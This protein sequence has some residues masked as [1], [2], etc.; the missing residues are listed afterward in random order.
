MGLGLGLGLNK[1]KGLIYFQNQ[2]S[3]YF[4]GSDDRVFT[5]ADAVAQPTSYSFWAKSSETGKNKGVFGHGAVNRGA[6]HFSWSSGM[7]LLYLSDTYYLYWGANAAQGDGKWHHWVVYSDTKNITNSKLYCD[8]VLQTIDIASSNTSGTANPYTEPLTIGAESSSQTANCFL[9]SMDEFAVFDRELTQAEITRMYNTYYTNN[10]VENGNFE[11][12]GGDIVQNGDFSEIGN[13]EVTNGTF[14]L[15][16]DVVENGDFSEIGNEE[17]TNGSFSEIGNEKITNGDFATDSDWTNEISGWTISNGKANY[18]GVNT[19]ASFQQNISLSVGK[20]YKVTYKISD[21]QQGDFRI[22]LGNTAGTINNSDGTYTEYITYSSGSIF[23]LQARSSFIGSID[24]VSVKEVGQDWGFGAG[25]GMG[26]G[27]AECDGTQTSGTQLTQTGLTLTN[28][29]IYK[30]TYK[31]TVSAGNIDARLQG[32]GATVTGPS[33]TSSD[34]YTDYLVS[35]G[36]TSF[37]MRG[38]DAFVGTVENISIKE[39]GQDWTLQNSS[40]INTDLATVVA[41]GAIS[42]TGNN[43]SLFQPNVFSP[44]KSYRIKFR[45]RQTN[46]SGNFNV[47]YGYG[48]I[49]DEVITSSFVDYCI[50]FTTTSSSWVNELTFGGYTTGDTFEVDD[51]VVQE[52]NWE[53]TQSTISGGEATITSTDGSY[54]GI[55]QTGV[56][57]VGKA[58]F[59]SFNVKSI[60]GTGQFRA[61]ANA[62]D[63]TTNGLITGYIIAT[64]SQTLEIKRIGGAFSAIIDNVIVKEVGQHWTLQNGWNMGDGVAIFSGSV[65]AY[66]KLFQDNFLN[67]G[68]QYK[69]TFEIKSISLGSIANIEP[70]SPSFNSTGVKTQYFTATFDDLYLEPTSD[71]VLTIDN[72]TVQ[73]V[74][75]NWTLNNGWSVDDTK[76][77]N[78]GSGGQIYPTS[79][80]WKSG[81]TTKFQITVSGRT[82]GHIRI[83]NPASSIYYVNNINTNDTFE[84]SFNTIDASGWRI[85]AVSGFDGSIDNIVVQQQKH[86]ATNLLVNSGDYQ[87]ANPLLTSTKSMYFDGIDSYIEVQDDSSLQLEASPSTWT[88]WARLDGLSD[89]D[90]KFIAKAVSTGSDLSG[91]QIRTNNADL[92]F[93]SYDGGW[94]GVTASSFFTDLNWVN[95]T[96]TLDSSNLASF[97]KN[98]VLFSSG[99]LGADIPANTGEMLF[100]ARTPAVPVNFLEGQMTEVGI[101]DRALTSLEVASLYN[102]G[103]PTDLLVNRNNYQSGNPTVFNTKQVDF[104]GI[105]DYMDLGSK[106]AT[107]SLTYSAWVKLTDNS[108][109]SVLQIG[110]TLLRLGNAGVIQWWSDIS[111]TELATSISSVEDEWSHIVVTQTGQNAFVYLNGVQENST[112]SQAVVSTSSNDSAIGKYVNANT[113]H[114]TGEISQVGVW[115]EALTADEVSSLYNHGLPIDLMTDQAAYESSSNLV[116]YWRMGSGTNDGFP[117]ISDQLSPSLDHISTTNLLTYS[118][119]F[120]QWTDYGASGV[121]SEETIFGKNAYKI[122]EDNT[123]N[124]HGVYL[125]NLF[126]ANGSSHS[127]SVYVKG[128]ERRYVVLTARAGIS[129]NASAIIFDTQEGEWVLD[130]SNQTQASSAESVGNG[131]WRIAITGDPTSAAYDSFT[132]A[133]SLGGTSYTDANYQ[134]DGTSGVY[135]YGAQLEQHPIATPYVKSN[136]IPGQRKSSTTNTLLYSEDFSKYSTGG[137][138]PTLTT[139]QLA[140]D[141]TFTATKVSGVSQ[142]TSLYRGSESST[143]ATRS[144]YARTV[145]GTGTANLMSYGSNTN[146]NFTITEE[147][148]RFELTGSNSTGGNNFYAVDFRFPGANPLTELIIWGGQSEEQTQATPYIKTVGSPVTVE[149]YKENNYAEM[150]NLGGGANFSRGIEN[151]SPYANI[152]RDSDFT[153]TGTQAQNIAGGYWTTGAGWTIANGVASCNNTISAHLSQN[154]LTLGVTYRV[155]YQIK[156]YT[157]GSVRVNAGWGGYGT[158]RSDEGTYTE[159]LVCTGNTFIE[160]TSIGGGFVGSIDNVTVTEVNTG[161]QG[162][163]KMGDGINDEYPVIYDQ[164]NPTLGSELLSQPVNL[165]AD[166]SATSGG[167]IVDADTFTTGGGSTDGIIK[168]VTT[169][170]KTYKLTIDGNTTSSGFTIGSGGSSGNEYGSGF[171]TFYFTALHATLWIRQ[172]T[173]GTTNITSFTLKQVGGNPATMTSMPEGNI[174]NQFP[175]TK[176]RNYYRMGDGILDSKFLSYP[177]LQSQAPYI[178]QDQTSPNLAHIPTTNLVTYS[179]DLSVLQKVSVGTASAPVTTSNYAAA[180]DG[181]QTATR[182]VFNLNGGTTNQD[183]SILR[184]AVPQG[185]NYYFSIY[186]KSTDGTEQKILWHDGGEYNLTTVTN[187]WVRITYDGR[188]NLVYS[189]I[190]LRGGDGVDSSDILAWGFQVEEQAQATAYLKSDGIAAVRKSSTTN[191]FLYSEDFENP[192]FVWLKAGTV[193][194]T[195]N[196]GVSPIGTQNSTR[197]VFGSSNNAFYRYSLHSGNTEANSI[198]VKGV[199]GETIKFGKG[200]TVNAGDIFTLNGSWQRLEYVSTTGNQF[201]INTYSGTTARDIQIWGAQIEEQ[202]QAETY[203]PTKGI[204]VTIDLFKENNYGHTQ[205]GVIQ[206]DVP[207]NS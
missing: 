180:P 74:G 183:R 101:Y 193:T 170:G 8:G 86:Q 56:F 147:W 42:S 152:V 105:D 182:V 202:T 32:G 43:W 151:G 192:L 59:Y 89:G 85:E 78:D 178:F 36:N 60:S 141:G 142:S 129:S 186:V 91:Y 29:K 55:K 52:T 148:Q 110:R 172:K 205:G 197:L 17:V 207:R 16:D 122:V 48:F 39:V 69:L 22:L 71:A 109:A 160:V 18:S 65:S 131:W 162:Y 53:V 19:I 41:S 118:E 125:A 93:Q 173:A 143:T 81:A 7:P 153:L 80:S 5:D 158:Y 200:S 174:T 26:D 49:L 98:G 23:Y 88:F 97:Y 47:G 195:S 190:A 15:G 104:D 157:S 187:E 70:N 9:G 38:N 163:W 57:D 12:I 140:P 189:G 13:E 75:Q 171:G 6:F 159:T 102:Q 134:G 10:L 103:V 115:N 188:A 176:L 203:A 37:R 194:P 135:I 61:G 45:A 112:S 83:Q 145:S 117:V 127:W 40:S 108:A 177:T 123:T 24:N 161:L 184:Q 35:T 113:W 130:S 156:D 139:G 150:V 191:K 34:T 137:T 155:S 120:S 2:Y 95:V 126:S 82:T 198:Y 94:N 154:A 84:Y 196:Y 96:I 68:S 100:G 87:S 181:T 62:V 51:I 90:Q 63:F 111:G 77:T 79:N 132:I 144:I 1:P 128:A 50:Y 149:F 201:T 167:L 185:S 44:S 133:A 30:V 64:S 106:S 67:I 114:F 116:G 121:L 119:D 164:T 54:A 204:P 166:F 25:W 14:D 146:N 92:L 168:N 20:I 21:R 31:V 206:K 58:Y 169:I 66:R 107:S 175:L 136:G 99:S 4:D 73:E 27:L 46:G 3:M 76:A 28:A 72:I 165:V 33:R 11:E 179:E 124:Y 138:A 199:S